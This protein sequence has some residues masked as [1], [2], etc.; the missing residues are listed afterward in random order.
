MMAASVPTT[1]TLVLAVFMT[2]LLLDVSHPL[3][4]NS[5]ELRRVSRGEL[6]NASKR[7]NV[8][9]TGYPAEPQATTAGE[10]DRPRVH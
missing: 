2:F 8:R 7:D 10:T 3:K 9:E 6:K 4:T 5:T 1:M